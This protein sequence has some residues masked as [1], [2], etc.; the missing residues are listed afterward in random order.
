MIPRVVRHVGLAAACAVL[1]TWTHAAAGFQE[2]AGGAEEALRAFHNGVN[3]YAAL[4]HKFEGPLP[5]RV[6]ARDTFSALVARRYLASAIRTARM[7]ARPGD[8]FDPAA[9]RVFRAMIA[10]VFSAPGG[11]ALADEFR[12]RAAHPVADPVV[13]EPYPME[14]AAVVPDPI[15]QRLPT[16]AGDV[17]YRAVN[18]DL[19]L[20]DVHAEIVVDVLP[21]ALLQGSGT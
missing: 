11:A 2:P 8:I 18:A 7:S 17:E 13:N 16:L 10:E 21:D 9:A 1:F 19:I 5:P 3:L 12:R 14:A 20:W 6:P 15:L 4:H